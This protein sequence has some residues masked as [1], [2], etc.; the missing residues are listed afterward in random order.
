MPQDEEPSIAVDLPW[1][2]ERSEKE[3]LPFPDA[4]QTFNFTAYMSI[5]PFQIIQEGYLRVRL[6]HRDE[7]IRVGSMKIMAKPESEA[8]TVL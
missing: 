5:V 1:K 7:R 3:E 6:I 8:E 2:Q 4:L